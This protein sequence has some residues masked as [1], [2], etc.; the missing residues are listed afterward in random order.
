MKKAQFM[1]SLDVFE[2]TDNLYP[3]YAPHTIKIVFRQKIFSGKPQE[4][5]LSLCCH[6]KKALLCKYLD[7]NEECNVQVEELNQSRYNN[8][9]AYK[10]LHIQLYMCYVSSIT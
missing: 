4:T 9:K 1:G 5:D 2:N 10:R 7:L 3:K 6:P 8:D